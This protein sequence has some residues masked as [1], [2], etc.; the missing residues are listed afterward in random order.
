MV[1]I[2]KGIPMPEEKAHG[3]VANARRVLSAMSVGDSVLVDGKAHQAEAAAFRE[4]ARRTG[5]K[6]A[7]QTQP[8]RPSKTRIWRKS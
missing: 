2:E 3:R 1:K 4:A 6:V 5:V 8:G 7:T